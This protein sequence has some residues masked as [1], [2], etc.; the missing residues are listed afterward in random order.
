MVEDL[1]AW[2]ATRGVVILPNGQLRYA[3]TVSAAPEN[4]LGETV[5]EHRRP[6]TFTK[7]EKEPQPLKAKRN[8]NSIF[9]HVLV[10]FSRFH[11]RRGMR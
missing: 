10:P 11:L 4:A 2:R 7:A 9:F 1:G 5:R 6:S 3:A 8:P